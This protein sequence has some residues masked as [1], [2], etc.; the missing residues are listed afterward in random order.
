MQVALRAYLGKRGFL[1][2][3]QSLRIRPKGNTGR[4]NVSQNHDA[5][6]TGLK[7]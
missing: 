7:K 4:G 2:V 1:R 6:L 5:Y 3:H